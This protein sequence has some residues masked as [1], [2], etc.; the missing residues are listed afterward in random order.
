[1]GLNTHLRRFELGICYTFTS[2]ILRAF[3]RRS[4]KD[5]ILSQIPYLD[6]IMVKYES[7]LRARIGFQVPFI[8]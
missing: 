7:S 4:K 2:T 6:L 3:N 5:E 1:M 8:H